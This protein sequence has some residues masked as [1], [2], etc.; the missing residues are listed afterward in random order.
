MEV[1]TVIDSLPGNTETL[2]STI[3]PSVVPSCNKPY[4][5]GRSV[6]GICT[7]LYIT[8]SEK[9]TWTCTNRLVP[10]N[11]K[12]S[13]KVPIPI[14]SKRNPSNRVNIISTSHILWKSRTTVSCTNVSTSCFTRLRTGGR[15][16]FRNATV[17]RHYTTH[18]N[19]VSRA[20]FLVTMTTFFLHNDAII[21][22]MAWNLTVKLALSCRF[23]F[24]L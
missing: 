20:T 3:G 12:T 2:R 15:Q 23:D 22:W 17:L 5:P 24:A 7:F 18:Q 8:P 1:I 11:R 9:L 6:P 13:V 4:V 21:V 10:W 16:H 19:V 14:R